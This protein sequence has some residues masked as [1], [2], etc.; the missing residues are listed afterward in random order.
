VVKKDKRIRLEFYSNKIDNYFRKSTAIYG[1][2]VWAVDDETGDIYR[3]LAVIKVAKKDFGT[4]PLPL[5]AAFENPKTPLF[6]Y[7][8]FISSGCAHAYSPTTIIGF[9]KSVHR[10]NTFSMIPG[11]APGRSGSAIFDITGRKVLG[12]ILR[13]NTAINVKKIYEITG[14]E[15][16]K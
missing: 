10:N 13:T 11:T 2:V 6:P 4:Y 3:D 15:V 16:P 1:K 14:W 8:G 12:I 9:V 7:R 5:I